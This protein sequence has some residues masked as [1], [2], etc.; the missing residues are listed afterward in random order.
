MSGRARLAPDVFQL[1][2]AAIRAGYYSDKYF[3]RA[4]EFR[5]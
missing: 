4:R 5:A 3:V 2:V 1:P